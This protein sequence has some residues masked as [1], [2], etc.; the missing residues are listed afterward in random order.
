MIMCRH[1][2]YI[3]T[4]NCLLF[5]TITCVYLF[6]IACGGGGGGSDS[7]GASGGTVPEDEYP[8]PSMLVVPD[9]YPEIQDAIDDMPQEGGTVYVRAGLYVINRGVHIKRSNVTILGEMGALVRL[10]DGVNQPVFLIGSDAQ[11]PS[12]YIENIKIS[13]LE[14]DGNMANQDREN[15]PARI[16]IRNNGIDVRMVNN[17][18]IADVN[19]HD[20]RSGGVVVSWGC[21]QIF[22]SDSYFH[23]NFFDGIALYDSENINV[24]NFMCF[25]N[26]SAG[27]SLD[28]ELSDVLFDNGIIE[29]NGDVGIFARNSEDIGFHDLMIADNQ[30]HGCFLSH[31]TIGTGTGVTRLYF[32]GC[33]FLDN[34]GYGFWLASP[35]S[36]SPNNAVTGCL[37]SGNTTGA[38]NL[39]AGALLDAEANIFQ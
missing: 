9:E 21:R 26:G 3:K 32:D 38:I 16:W 33:S 36:E 22:I 19:I 24:I 12:T 17:L 18:R 5:I 23:N 1:Y 10:G 8:T 15:D 6:V 28:N 7:G 14:I 27:L 39:D 20:A 29:S 35:A 2:K 34:A 31:E 11:T 4:V 13:N 30:N 25:N 37:F